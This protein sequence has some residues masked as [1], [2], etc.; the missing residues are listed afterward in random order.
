MV[1]QMRTVGARTELSLVGAFR[2]TSHKVPQLIMETLPFAMLVGTMLAFTKLNRL[3]ELSAIRA[4][5]VS[6]WRFLGPAIII[7]AV[8]GVFGVTVLDPLATTASSRFDALRE[9]FI[10]GE[11]PLADKNDGSVWLRQGDEFGRTVIHGAEVEEG[12]SAL[13]G[14]VVLVFETTD[15]GNTLFRRRIDA[16]RAILRPGFWQLEGVVENT[17]ELPPSEQDFLALPTTLEPETLLNRYASANTIGFWD[18]P[19]FIEET[20][21]A[22]LEQDQYVLRFPFSA[23]VANLV[24]GHG[25]DWS[26]CVFAAASYWWGITTNRSW[27]G[28]RVY[29]LLCDPVCK[30]SCRIRRCTSGGGSL[31]S[32]IVLLFL[33]F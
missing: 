21:R 10:H 33:P 12:G 8:L 9:E 27:R 31:V 4:A 19:K 20:K 16:D 6:A 15:E 5:G 23:G 1:E 2:L 22:G 26:G 18:L 7:S 17:P 32:A 29:A 3:S 24:D 14:V 11:R 30:R 13:L 28:G 25:V